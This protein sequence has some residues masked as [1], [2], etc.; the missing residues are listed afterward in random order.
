LD[1]ELHSSAS[2][3]TTAQP[4]VQR[5]YG[6]AGRPRPHL[7]T[8]ERKLLREQMADVARTDESDR[9]VQRS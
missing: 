2:A 6:P 5:V 4:V 7:V 8:G 3:R 9:T 1:V